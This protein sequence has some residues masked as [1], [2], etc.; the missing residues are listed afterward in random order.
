M[1]PQF[2]RSAKRD[3]YYIEYRARDVGFRPVRTLERNGQ[4]F[5]QGDTCA[6]PFIVDSNPYR[7]ENVDISLF[8]PDLQTGEKPCTGYANAGRDVVFFVP[9]EAGQT[10]SAVVT[11]DY[12]AALYIVQDCIDM[13]C[14]AGSDDNL[15]G[16][17]ETVTYTATAKTTV[18][19][20]VD[21]YSSDGPES[22]LFTITI[23]R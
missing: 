2:A 9:L 6:N 11:A 12:D 15:A 8:Q 17:S 16:E 21:H 20:V 4:A 3:G 13:V 10:V 7:L 14:L 1:A 5:R 23:S 19:I 22:G 18:Y